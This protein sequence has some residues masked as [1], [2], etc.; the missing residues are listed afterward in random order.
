[1][2]FIAMTDPIPSLSRQHRLRWNPQTARPRGDLQ[3]TASG[4]E[5]P[6]LFAMEQARQTRPE[7]MRQFAENM[8]ALSEDVFAAL[9]LDLDT[10]SPYAEARERPKN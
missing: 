2:K 6:T 4:L 3:E 8:P 1:M 10:P 5:T 7:R 9:S